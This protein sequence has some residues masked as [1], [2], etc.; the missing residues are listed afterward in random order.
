V[1][2]QIH[3]LEAQQVTDSQDDPS[4]KVYEDN[5][6]TKAL[7]ISQ[8]DKDSAGSEA[9]KKRHG[10]TVKVKNNIGGRTTVGQK[11]SLIFM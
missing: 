3:I 6:V 5:D 7:A 8:K 1:E 4:T 2:E 9:E 11:V 10:M